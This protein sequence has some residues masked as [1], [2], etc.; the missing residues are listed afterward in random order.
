MIVLWKLSCPNSFAIIML[1]WAGVSQNLFDS[2]KTFSR[3]SS[4]WI[5]LPCHGIIIEVL[6]FPGPLSGS[7]TCKLLRFQSCSNVEVLKYK[8]NKVCLNTCKTKH[9]IIVLTNIDTNIWVLK[10]NLWWSRVERLRGS[11]DWF[12]LRSS[13]SILLLRSRIVKIWLKL[14][15]CSGNTGILYITR[16][17]KLT[18]KQE[19]KT[20]N[21]VLK[22]HVNEIKAF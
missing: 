5:F 21:L 10:S 7:S 8:K 11:G 14:M 2:A 4:V 9:C 1:Y 13:T 17:L 3:T 12:V 6:C 19:S 22:W 18:L 20:G 16:V 15:A